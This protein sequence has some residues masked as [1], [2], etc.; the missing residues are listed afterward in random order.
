MLQ[1]P[2]SRTVWFSLQKFVPS[3]GRRG[4]PPVLSQQ[5]RNDPYQ[6]LF[7]FLQDEIP[8]QVQ[9]VMQVR[10]LVKQ[11]TA[12]TSCYGLPPLVLGTI[13]SSREFGR[14]GSKHHDLISSLKPT[15]YFSCLELSSTANLVS[16]RK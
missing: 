8:P 13:E 7:C 5:V 4:A 1:S 12:K 10:T 16:I 15:S 11:I 6:L 14:S 9:A 3:P 2:F